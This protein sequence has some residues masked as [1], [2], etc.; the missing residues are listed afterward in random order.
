[1]PDYRK[2]LETMSDEELAA[3]EDLAR[4]GDP[5]SIRQVHDLADSLSVSDDSR[6]TIGEDGWIVPLDTSLFVGRKPHRKQKIFLE[7]RAREVFFG[8]ALGGGKSEALIHSMLQYVHVPKYH[9]IIFRRTEPNCQDLVD[10]LKDMLKGGGHAGFTKEIRGGR[11]TF[12]SG[13]ML[14]IGFMQHADD[15]FNYKGPEYT[16]VAYDELTEFLKIQYTYMFS[17]M[18]TPRCPD[19]RV[20]ETECDLCR[21]AGLL[22]RIPLQVLSGSNP[23]GIGAD[24]VCER[25]VGEDAQDDIENGDTKDIYDYGDRVFVPSLFTDNPGIDADIY[26]DTLDAG[27]TEAE[28]HQLKDGSWKRPSGTIFKEEQFRR[29]RADRSTLIPQTGQGEDNKYQS[30]STDECYRFATIDVAHTSAAKAREATSKKAGHSWSVC[31]LWDY[32]DR[33]GPQLY[34]RSIWRKRVE[35]LD[36]KNGVIEF[37]V[38]WKPDTVV[39]EEVSGS[40]S[41]V[42]ELR[43]VGGFEVRTFNPSQKR[44]KGRGGGRSGKADRSHKFQLML[45][46]GQVY[47]PE[48]R[49]PWVNRYITELICWHGMDHETADQVDVSSMAAF[50]VA[51]QTLT[52]KESNEIIEVVD[53]IDFTTPPSD[54]MWSWQ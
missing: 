29:Y 17:R 5:D 54:S 44:F 37:L 10:R 42:A 12:P 1:M 23:D 39:I 16:R 8:G 9:A 53:M 19:H 34:L 26:S 43:M 45:E 51:D 28:R 7:S 36:L 22:S 40:K 46:Q 35:W 30:V 41:L 14:D 4:S 3:I 31:A 49:I 38:S 11:F 33:H 15:R 6:I 50:E 24:W 27:L 21:T 48:E 25:F 2:I 13:A 47:V 20:F 18:R 32:C 52:P